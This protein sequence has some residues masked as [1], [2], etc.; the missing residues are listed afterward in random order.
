MNFNPEKAPWAFETKAVQERPP[1][2]DPAGAVTSPIYATST[3]ATGNA[4]GY[5]YTRSGNPGFHHL[6]QVLASLE[7]AAHATVFGSGVA[8]ITAVVS[9]LKSGDLI[10]AEENI[11]GC[12]FRLFHQVFDK[13]GLRVAYADFTDPASFREIRKL[14]PRLLWLESP[15]NPLLK[16]IDIQTL[17][18][19]ARAVGAEVLVDNT[20]ASGYLQRPL[21]LGA[22][23]SLSSTTKYVN[24]H[25]DCLGGVVCTNDK[26]WAERL[27]FAQKALGLNPSPFDAWL[28]V[29]GAKTLALRMERH[30]KN[31][32]QVARFL[33][34][35]PGVRWVRYPFLPSHPQYHLA[36]RQMRL[37]GGMVTADLGMS[38]EDTRDFLDRLQLFTLA[39]SLGGVESLACHPASM[40]HASVPR[41]VREQ[42][43]ITDSVV[44]FSVGVEHLDD[45][46]HDLRSTFAQ[47]PN[48]LR[49][50]LPKEDSHEKSTAVPVLA[51]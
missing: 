3:F 47:K 43:G 35:Q 45:L 37:G 8:A 16:I 29:R 4:H 7:D 32:F 34:A 42:V 5:D 50:H 2:S 31:A 17:A 25:S 12:T 49:V 19:H 36:R 39:E 11:Y 20:F 33:E 38:L 1:F 21:A 26:V 15:T 51:S 41:A 18:H 22:T 23:L 27:D 14:R 13:F 28:I 10:L 48:H 46:L 24:G 44:R 6:A 40:T 9:S 30:H